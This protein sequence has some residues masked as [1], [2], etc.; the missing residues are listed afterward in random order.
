MKCGNIGLRFCFSG[1]RILV[2]PTVVEEIPHTK[3]IICITKNGVASH[4][5]LAVYQPPSRHL[6]FDVAFQSVDRRSPP[7]V[8]K[9]HLP[10]FQESRK[11]EIGDRCDAGILRLILSCTIIHIPS[12]EFICENEAP[13][14]RPL[15]SV[16]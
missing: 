14:Q 8:S 16:R 6:N 2:R 1:C 10:R 4:E 3:A 12:I 13:T 5:V 11:R 15:P 9:V 7:D